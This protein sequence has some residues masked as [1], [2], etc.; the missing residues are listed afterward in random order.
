MTIDIKSFT[1]NRFNPIVGRLINIYPLAGLVNLTRARRNPEGIIPCRNQHMMMFSGLRGAVAFALALRDTKSI[2]NQLMFSTTLLIVYSTVL[3]LG[4]GT[5]TM[6][7]KLQI[8]GFLEK[9]H[10]Q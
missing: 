7:S 10:L 3:V 8:P 6:L 9:L 1:L 4:G 2:P 5:T